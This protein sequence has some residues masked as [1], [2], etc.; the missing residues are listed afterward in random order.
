VDAT[1]HRPAFAA[2][3][4]S[5]GAPACALDHLHVVPR[6]L[7]SF[8]IPVAPYIPSH[9]AS[10]HDRKIRTMKLIKY[11]ANL[12]YG[13][14]RDAERIVQQRRVTRA[15]GTVL[16]EGAAFEHGDMLIDG[17]PIDPPSG[18]VIM[19]HKPVGYV[20]STKDASQLVYELL[21]P[22]FPHRSPVMA[23]IGRLDR[24]TSGLLL[25]TDDGQIN[26][27]ITSPR[28]HLPKVYDATLTS[29]LRGDEADVFASGT[30]M[31]E[32]ETTPLAPATMEVLDARHARVTLTE[33]RY[34][35]VRRMFAAVGNHVQAL[36]RSA[37]G[38]LELGDL[39]P[40]EWRVLGADEIARLVS[41]AST[42]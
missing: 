36:H 42:R 40:G 12:G 4:S 19:L 20:C 32:S 3:G 22:R 37:I 25:L 38:S 29:D 6:P 33:G 24:D 27:R 7:D 11:L 8:V 21:P 31:L 1:A 23:P 30:L 10:H 18:S 16:R 15:D 26:H 41:S 39:Q 13:T 17:E 9:A 2:S 5:A 35:Q 28:T 34:H 14:R